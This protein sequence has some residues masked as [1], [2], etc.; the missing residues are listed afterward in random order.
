MFRFQPAML[1]L[2]LKGFK[3]MTKKISTESIFY[4]PGHNDTRENVQNFRL[5]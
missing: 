5:R 3:R 1:G 2:L 4:P